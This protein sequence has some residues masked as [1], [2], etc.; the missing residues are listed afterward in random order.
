M[1]ITSLRRVVLV[2]WRSLSIRSSTMDGMTRIGVY[3]VAVD[4]DH[5]LLT[6]LWSRDADPGRW[7]LP[8]GGMEFGE[9][10]HETLEREFYEE[11]G[12]EPRIGSVL[13]VISYLP[14]PDLHVIQ[15]IFDVEA[16]GEPRVIEVGGST[17]DARW[18][19]TGK[20]SGLPTVSLVNH[21][22][23]VRGW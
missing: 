3:G 4:R 14:R 9:T 22:L 1:P 11:T 12:L 5:L 2:G 19:P 6:Q 20:V 16:K 17:I 13:D 7:T 10:P 18:V 15:M 8:G 21:V 23:S